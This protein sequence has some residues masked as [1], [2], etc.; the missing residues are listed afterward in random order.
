M[1]AIPKQKEF[2][3]NAPDETITF[4]KQMAKE[5]SSGDTICLEGDL[6]AGKTHFVKG[7]AAG[8]GI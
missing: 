7:L 2:I 5:L 3:S 4:G 8:L 1:M 6:G